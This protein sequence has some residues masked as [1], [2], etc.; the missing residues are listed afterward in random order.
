MEKTLSVVMPVYNEQPTLAT[1]IDKVLAVPFV[2]ELI[3]VNDCSTDQSADI[4]DSY[5]HIPSIKVIHHP[6][7]RGKGAAIR[8]GIAHITGQVTII[9]DADLE[10]DP[11]DYAKLIQP[12]LAGQQRVVYGSRFLSVHLNK[13]KN[14]VIVDRPNLFWAMLGI[15]TTIVS[16]II[17]NKLRSNQIEQPHAVFFL[18]GVVV[19]LITNTLYGQRLTDE[20]TCYKTFESALLKSIDLQCERFEF[21]PEVTAKV[22]RCGIKI[23]EIPIRYYP[24]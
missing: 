22:A 4:L 17:R 6:H 1:I 18:G 2:K 15:I 24:R 11:Q 12:I 21:C 9:Q 19:T 3:I 20:P 7:N 10:Y 14:A 8:T 13:Q 5:R 16:T 23:M